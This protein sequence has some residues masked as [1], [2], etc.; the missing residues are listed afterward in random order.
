IHPLNSSIQSFPAFLSIFRAIFLRLNLI[1]INHQFMKQNLSYDVKGRVH[2]RKTFLPFSFSGLLIAVLVFISC[3]KTEEEAPR[4]PG[5]SYHLNVSTAIVQ[6][7]PSAGGS[8][9]VSI[10]ANAEWRI[11]LP[12]G[13]DWMEVD[14]TSGTGNDSLHVKVTKENNTG[15]KRTAVLTVALVN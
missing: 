6:S 1:N 4:P 14:K 15:A 5:P 7:A 2:Y 13:A 8:T 3:K 10:D 11:T 12:S 9:R